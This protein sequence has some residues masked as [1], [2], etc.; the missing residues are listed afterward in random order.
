MKYVY[1]ATDLSAIIKQDLMQKVVNP[2]TN[3]EPY[4]VIVEDAFPRS[5]ELAVVVELVEPDENGCPEEVGG[6]E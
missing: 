5:E 1:S 6:A 2:Y 4:G 3:V